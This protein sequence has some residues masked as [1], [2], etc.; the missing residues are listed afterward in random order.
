ME[1]STKELKR[2]N[3]AKDE[4]LLLSL[5]SQILIAF[6]ISACLLQ[7][8]RVISRP[9]V[10]RSTDWQLVDESPYVY[11]GIAKG[12]HLVG[13]GLKIRIEGPEWQPKPSTS[14]TGDSF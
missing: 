7:P 4:R 1:A 13:H 8:E 12:D 5:L 10:A 9:S 6:W 2:W 14:S 11:G 3:G